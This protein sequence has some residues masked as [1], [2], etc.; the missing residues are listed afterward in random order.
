MRQNL[1]DTYIQFVNIKLRPLALEL[2][3]PLYSTS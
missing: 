2:L 3:I 1:I